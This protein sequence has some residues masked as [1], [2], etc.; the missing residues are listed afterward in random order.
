MV[1]DNIY[2]TH[3][4]TQLDRNLFFFLLYFPRQKAKISF[5]THFLTSFLLF[6]QKALKILCL[7]FD[8]CC[9]YLFFSKLDLGVI[10]KWRAQLLHAAQ[11]AKN[12]LTLIYIYI[13]L[14]RILKNICNLRITNLLNFMFVMYFKLSLGW[15]RSNEVIK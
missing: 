15:K 10:N 5:L 3:L 13:G 1:I 11:S 8:R 7:Y 9:N 6:V 2:L 14:N 4:Y 12:N